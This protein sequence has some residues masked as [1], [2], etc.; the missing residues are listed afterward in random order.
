MRRPV[1]FTAHVSSSSAGHAFFLRVQ[2]RR[3]AAVVHLS[4]RPWSGPLTG[5]ANGDLKDIKTSNGRIGYRRFWAPNDQRLITEIYPRHIHVVI[6][7][8]PVILIAGGIWLN[9]QH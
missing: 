6:M 8:V 1:H 4:A 7:L 3:F 9:A 2:T 5:F